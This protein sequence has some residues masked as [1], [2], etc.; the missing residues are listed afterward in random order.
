[1]WSLVHGVASLA[2]GGDLHQVGIHE[3]SEALAA[4]AIAEVL[5]IAEPG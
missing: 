4:R 3:D 2:I 1:M 5:E